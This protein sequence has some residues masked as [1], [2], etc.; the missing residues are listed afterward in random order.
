MRKYVMAVTATVGIMAAAAGLRAAG[1][2]IPTVDTFRDAFMSDAVGN[3]LA[4]TDRIRSE[5]T[6]FGLTDR[7]AAAPNAFEATCP[8]DRC[9]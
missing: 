4:W 9:S 2:A 5:S 1:S 7:T 8:A 3:P 6:A